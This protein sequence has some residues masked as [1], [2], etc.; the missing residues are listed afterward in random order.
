MNTLLGKFY[1]CTAK[2]I[3]AM[4]ENSMANTKLRRMPAHPPQK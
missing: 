4:D 3:H 2:C 1:V